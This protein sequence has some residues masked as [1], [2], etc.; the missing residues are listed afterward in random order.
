MDNKVLVDIDM[1][2]IISKNGYEYIKTNIWLKATHK[3]TGKDVELKLKP[4][5]PVDY[6][7][8]QYA[9]LMYSSIDESSGTPTVKLDN[10]EARLFKGN[11]YGK[12]YY[13]VKAIIDDR[14]KI[15]CFLDDTQILMV[16]NYIELNAVFE[17][18]ASK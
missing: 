2:Y 13:L 9:G 15:S 1:Q 6:N 5:K 18:I 16:N 14:M 3:T 11:Y 17:E 4:K 12:D 7:H 8:W 10:V